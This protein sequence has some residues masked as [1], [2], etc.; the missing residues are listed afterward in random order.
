MVRYAR[1]GGQLKSLRRAV[2]QHLFRGFVRDKALRHFPTWHSTPQHHI[3]KRPIVFGWVVACSSA[4]L[5][6]I[7]RLPKRVS[8][9][10]LAFCARCFL[11]VVLKSPAAKNLGLRQCCNKRVERLVG[12]LAFGWMV[13]CREVYAKPVRVAPLGSLNDA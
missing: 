1:C 11:R 5:A 7:K 10:A 9:T 12:G 4:S 13:R 3:Q 2:W 6:E 8:P